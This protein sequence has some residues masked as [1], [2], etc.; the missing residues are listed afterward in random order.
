MKKTKGINRGRTKKDKGAKLPLNYFHE[1]SRGGGGGPSFKKIP[2]SYKTMIGKSV[3][4][5][6]AGLKG[7]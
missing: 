1:K 3:L 7:L 2:N 4:A 6:V 5:G